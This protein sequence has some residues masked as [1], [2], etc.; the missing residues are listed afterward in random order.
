MSFAAYLIKKSTWPRLRCN[1]LC[2]STGSKRC[3]KQAPPHRALR[4]KPVA[5]AI[6]TTWTQHC[7]HL[8]T[9]PPPAARAG[10]CLSDGAGRSIHA[11]ADG[12]V[13]DRKR[14]HPQ[15]SLRPGRRLPQPHRPRSR[16]PTGNAAA[17]GVKIDAMLEA[18]TRSVGRAWTMFRIGNDRQHSNA[19]C[20]ALCS[21]NVMR[22]ERTYF[23]STL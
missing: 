20:A 8:R 14:G 23:R 3:V 15:R 5:P 21:T 17:A 2:S 16:R 6:G 11:A 18:M 12:P 13:P 4:I 7:D 10:P 22:A 9:I 1:G 19:K